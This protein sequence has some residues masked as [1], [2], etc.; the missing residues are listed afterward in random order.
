MHTNKKAA[1]AGTGTASN[2]AFNS[3][4][5]TVTAD[6]SHDPN[7]RQVESLLVMRRVS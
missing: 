2:T 5:N 3:A 4:N 1:P 6:A 7:V